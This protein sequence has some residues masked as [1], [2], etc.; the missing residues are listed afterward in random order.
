M[1]FYFTGIEFETV[2]NVLPE[3]AGNPLLWSGDITVCGLIYVGY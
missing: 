3:I 1:L 2:P